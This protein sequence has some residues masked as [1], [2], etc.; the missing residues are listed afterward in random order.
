MKGIIW[1]WKHRHRQ[2]HTSVGGKIEPPYPW[3]KRNMPRPKAEMIHGTHVSKMVFPITDEPNPFEARHG[4]EWPG[5]P[6]SNRQNSLAWLQE[7]PALLKSHPGWFV[8]YQDGKRVALEPDCDKL[9]KAL[10]DALGENRRPVEFHEIIEEP[11]V[12]RGP[13]PR[14]AGYMVAGIDDGIHKAHW[15]V[16]AG[17]D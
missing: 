13:S 14:Y 9:V 15:S 1:L 6:P 17:T 7:K 4:K 11:I 12:H 3:P 5:P 2:M 10:D 8:A 16:D